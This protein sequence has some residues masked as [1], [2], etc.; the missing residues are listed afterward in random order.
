MLLTII[1]YQRK[2]YQEFKNE[3]VI[4][5]YRGN[6]NPD[7]IALHDFVEH[8]ERGANC[9]TT[10]VGVLNRLGYEVSHF[11]S[12][13]L[14]RDGRE[15]VL[16]DN[17]AEVAHHDVIL[18]LPEDGRTDPRLGHTALALIDSGT[19][20]LAHNALG[21]GHT[22]IEPALHEAQGRIAAIKR[23]IA[24][25]NPPDVQFLARVGLQPLAAV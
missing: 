3:R 2:R 14:A 1:L 22:V 16:I 17:F 4:I 8:P 10:A 21:H 9:Q 19:L 7:T 18:Y 11:R 24:R 6:R 25:P 20:Y 5:P 23:P 12:L 13:E 15:T